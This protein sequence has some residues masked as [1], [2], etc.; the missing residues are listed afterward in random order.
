M[1]GGSPS[2][3]EDMA[4]GKLTSIVVAPNSTFTQFWHGFSDRQAVSFSVVVSGESAP[5]VLNPLG[6]V[7]FT[8]DDTLRHV[9]GTIGRFIVVQNLAPFNPAIVDILILT[10][11]F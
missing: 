5:G 11:S 6:H 10:E 3:G 2:E 4:A 1:A 8:Q 7:R 9:D